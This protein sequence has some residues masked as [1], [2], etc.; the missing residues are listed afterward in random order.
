MGHGLN[1]EELGRNPRL[2][3]FFVRDLNKEP[4]GWALASDSFDAV[5]CC[6]SVQYLQYPERVFAEIQR[7]L[8]PGGVCIVTFTH[9][10]FYDKAVSA[11]RDAS[12]YS[13]VQLVKQYFMAVEGF[14]EPESLTSVGLPAVSPFEAATRAVQQLFDGDIDPFHAV[15]SY[16]DNV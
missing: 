8:R 9:N 5:L 10:M 7:V 1:A 15:V 13:R 3:H 14:T 11:W 12:M 2:S 16:K 6:C 4:D